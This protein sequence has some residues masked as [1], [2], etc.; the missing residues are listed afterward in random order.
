MENSESLL[1]SITSHFTQ[2][3][4]DLEALFRNCEY[5]TKR[6]KYENMRREVMEMNR[7][8]LGELDN[9][10]DDEKYTGTSDKI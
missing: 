9:V 2:I 3:D 7:E 1:I 8:I 6:N 4:H 5:E 10:Y